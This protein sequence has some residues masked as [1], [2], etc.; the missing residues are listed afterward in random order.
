MMESV[1]SLTACRQW[2]QRGQ[3]EDWV[4]AYLL[5]DG[6]NVP[7]SEG[8][9]LE[10]RIYH[11]PVSMPAALF[12]RCSGPADEGLQ[13]QVD[14]GWWEYKVGRITEAV[15]SGADLPPLIVNYWIPEGQT[16]GQF[17]VNDGN[18]RLEVCHQLGINLC[19][20][21]LWCTHQQELNQLMERYGHLMK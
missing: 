3:L 15:R 19:H 17:V 16:D 9:K 7:F 12:K 6:D 4:H 18:H 20:V 5:S 11:G 8:L 1:N 10:P 2:A 13:F 14:R 21:V